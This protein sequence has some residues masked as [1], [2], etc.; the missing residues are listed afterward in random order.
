MSILEKVKLRLGITY[1]D[2]LKDMELQSIIDGCIADMR[3]SG[4]PFEKV[5]SPLA[6]ENIIIYVRQQLDTN[7]QT[8]N[9]V[10]LSNIIKLRANYEI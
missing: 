2:P 10:Y 5:L 8:I 7:A 1:T 4:V 3:A 6:V 9:P